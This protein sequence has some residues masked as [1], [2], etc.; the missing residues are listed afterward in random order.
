MICA[1]RRGRLTFS[2]LIGCL[3]S[4]RSINSV[5]QGVHKRSHTT[6]I[7]LVEQEDSLKGRIER[8]TAIVMAEED[9]V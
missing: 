3:N 2:S 8:W 9:A 1:W 6:S 4:L 7:C 5:G